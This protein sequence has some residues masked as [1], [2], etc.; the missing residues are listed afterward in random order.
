MFKKLFLILVMLLFA[1][2]V[3]FAEGTQ[4]F[5][6]L[7]YA[8]YTT[9]EE[10]PVNFLNFPSHPLY[11]KQIANG[12]GVIG[13]VEHVFSGSPETV[14]CMIFTIYGD[15]T[16][17][18]A[19]LHVVVSTIIKGVDPK[20][21]VTTEY[22]DRELYETGKPSRVLTKLDIKLDMK[23]FEVERI[24]ALGKLGT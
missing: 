13:A 20:K 6:L 19:I 7:D 15:E 24:I 2:G 9:P 5:N 16:Y 14:L 8:I 3:S 18:L 17:N 11:I 21:W 10:F 1:V 12:K 23:K 4:K 22:Y